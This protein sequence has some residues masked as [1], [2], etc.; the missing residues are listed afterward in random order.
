M[1]YSGGVSV[2]RMLLP[3]LLAWL[4]IVNPGRT[5]EKIMG[6]KSEAGPVANYYNL[7]K[8]YT[9]WHEGLWGSRTY[10]EHELEDFLKTLRGKFIAT[11]REFMLL[12]PESLEK[13][14]VIC[15]FK[16]CRWLKI[17][18]PL[19]RK[20]LEV[21]VKKNPSLLKNWW[22]S[23]KLLS[24]KGRIRKFRLT[25]DAGGDIIELWLKEILP[26]P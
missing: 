25:R 12:V 11:P 5:E 24:I 7:K 19:D 15:K 9:R 4:C 10:N 14:R 16:T 26:L 20:S 1:K 3:A 17:Y 18:G 2:C 23:R 13:P 8:H 22:R 6:G 21:L